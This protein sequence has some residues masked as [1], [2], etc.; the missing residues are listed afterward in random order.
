MGRLR[1]GMKGAKGNPVSVT[2]WIFSS[3]NVKALETVANLYGGTVER[4]DGYQSDTHRVMTTTSRIRV[5]L[6]PEPMGDSMLEMWTGRG[7]QRRCDGVTCTGYPKDGPPK[8][9]ECICIPAQSQVAD[10][11]ATPDKWCKP[12]TRLAV[13]V[14]DLPLGGVW[15]MSTSGWN[16]F[17]EIQGSVELLQAASVRGFPEA[18]LSL[19]RR[20]GTGRTYVVPMLGMAASFDQLAVGAAP[21]TAPALETPVEILAELVEGDDE[22]A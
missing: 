7:I 3:S 20:K 17:R 5:M 13:I 8:E 19:E 11:D 18:E 12:K 14:P 6:P 21:S 2:D 22:W 4:Y 16:A 1:F 15:Q 10:P 9:V